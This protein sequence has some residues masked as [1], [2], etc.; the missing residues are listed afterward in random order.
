[1]REVSR[2]RRRP[3]RV[4]QVLPSAPVPLSPEAGGAYEGLPL[5]RGG[6][7]FL[8]TIETS[9]APHKR[10]LSSDALFR[11]CEACL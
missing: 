5:P 11:M 3:K 6:P 1:M 8:R 10:L 4:K 2:E 9:P 7:H